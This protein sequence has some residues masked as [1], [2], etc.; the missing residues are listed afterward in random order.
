MHTR[1]QIHAPQA[2]VCAAALAATAAVMAAVAVAF[3]SASAEPWLRDSPAAQRVA[4]R[5]F[6]LEGREARQAC[7]RAAVAQARERDAGLMRLA[8]LP[9]GAAASAQ[10]P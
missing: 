3:H 2:I 9:Q 8:A 10:A 6:A 1:L 5:C 7:V 4:G